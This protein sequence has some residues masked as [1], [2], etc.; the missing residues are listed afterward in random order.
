MFDSSDLT[1]IGALKMDKNDPLAQFRASFHLPKTD[2]GADIVYLTGNSLGLQPKATRAAITEVL[3]DWATLGVEGHFKAKH[4]WMQYHGLLTRNMAAIVGAEAGEVV[5]MNSL[6]VN[7]HLLMASFFKPVGKRTK[8]LIEHHAFPSDRYAVRSHLEWHG[9]DPDKHLIIAGSEDILDETEVESILAKNGDEIALVMM[10]GV[11][12]YSG[13]LF[14]MARIT[15]AGHKAGAMVGFDLAHAAGNVLLSLHDWKVD[16][17]AWCSYKYLNAGPG[18]PSGA[19]VHSKHG[20]NPSI[21]RLSGWWGHDSESRF[22]MPDGFVPTKGAEGW[23][24]SN[25]SILSMAAFRV[26]LEVFEQ[27]GLQELIKK[28][29]LLT[30]YTEALLLAKCSDQIEI[31]TPGTA[32]RRGA[33]LSIRVLSR[34]SVSKAE[35][36]KSET[37]SYGKLVFTHLEK[38]GVICDWREPDVIRLAPVPLYNSFRDVYLFVH[39]LQLALESVHADHSQGA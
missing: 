8:I 22:K 34:P 23:Q 9:L 15:R 10:G 25:P 21:R 12:Y 33:Q 30:A 18:G 32:S 16:F 2:S 1:E 6:T 20:S 19:F 7:L 3:D 36:A 24:L 35:E 39:R 17:A 31:I 13:Q 5:V 28:S 27:A 14:D 29:R 4:A 11:N 38:S 37:P 26:S